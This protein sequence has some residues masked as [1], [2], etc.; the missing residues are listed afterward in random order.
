MWKFDSSMIRNIN[1]ESFEWKKI[2]FED[3]IP[4]PRFGHTATLYQKKLYIFGGKT[5]LNNYSIISDI[6]IYYIDELMF[7]TPII[8]NKVKCKPRKNHIA[9]LIG[10][11]ILIHG[12]F[13][14]DNSVLG[15]SYLLNLDYIRWSCLDLK[16]EIYS[17]FFAGHASCLVLP[18]D[19][20][21]NSRL[22]I[23]K[24]EERKKRS[25]DKVSVYCILD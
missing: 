10:Y 17:P 7:H 15:T 21:Q 8:P 20:K 14:E 12:G 9:E 11:Q 2:K 22:N 18:Y 16:D 13:N 5:K 4:N 1:L 6:E 25:T 19:I 23:Y 3:C 24:F